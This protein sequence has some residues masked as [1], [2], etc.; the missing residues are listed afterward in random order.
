M[1]S[2]QIEVIESGSQLKIKGNDIHF[3]FIHGPREYTPDSPDFLDFLMKNGNH[4]QFW[5]HFMA[6]EHAVRF[7]SFADAKFTMEELDSN[8]AGLLGRLFSMMSSEDS[9][10][11]TEDQSYAVLYPSVKVSPN[12]MNGTPGF[13]EKRVTYCLGLGFKSSNKRIYHLKPGSELALR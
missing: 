1:F 2:F 11:V 13:Q 4:K 5:H 3:F 6:E 12:S 7:V 9:D 10:L 8:P